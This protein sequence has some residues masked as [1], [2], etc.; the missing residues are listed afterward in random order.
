MTTIRLSWPS[1]LVR[2]CD[3]LLIGRDGG[4][5]HIWD[6]E[7]RKI[8]TGPRRCPGVGGLAIAFQ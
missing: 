8:A 2:A 6:I 5:A 7:A 3:K 4:S 1:V